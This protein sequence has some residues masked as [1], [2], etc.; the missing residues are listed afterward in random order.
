MNVLE[1]LF[2]EDDMDTM[3][4]KK[5]VNLGEKHVIII[6]SLEVMKFTC[7]NADC[8]YGDI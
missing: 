3:E 7:K 2:S 6:S 1:K 8:L 4:M 5:K